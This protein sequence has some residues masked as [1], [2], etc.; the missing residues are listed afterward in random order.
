MLE[1][2]NIIYFYFLL[3]LTSNFKPW[4]IKNLS[5]KDFQFCSKRSKWLLCEELHLVQQCYPRLMIVYVAENA[6]EA[7]AISPRMLAK[8]LN[9]GNPASLERRIQRELE[10]QGLWTYFFFF[11]LDGA[12]PLMKDH[13][14]ERP[15]PF[16][17]TTSLTPFL[18]H[19]HA[20]KPLTQAT[21]LP[22][23]Q[24]KKLKKVFSFLTGVSGLNL[25]SKGHIAVDGSHGGSSDGCADCKQCFFILG[26][27]GRG[28]WS[29]A[30]HD[31]EV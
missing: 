26:A 28:I 8:Q 25:H 18:S 31:V 17:K 20:K 23:N 15:P 19:F 6:E 7:P 5:G 2:E 30:W 24:P 3:C 14:D 9:I 21:P 13:P 22:H 16:F 10:E 12:E 29:P 27:R 11:F 4:Y 1:S